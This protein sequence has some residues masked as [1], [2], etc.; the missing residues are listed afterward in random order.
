[1]IDNLTWTNIF[2]H[3]NMPYNKGNKMQLKYIG[4]TIIIALHHYK[5]LKL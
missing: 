2:A 1:M 4:S 5:Y 3:Q